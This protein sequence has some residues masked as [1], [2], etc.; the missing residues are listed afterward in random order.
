MSLHTTHECGRCL[1]CSYT[2]GMLGQH[3]SPYQI[4]LVGWRRI[5]CGV[6]GAIVSVGA[7]F[8]H[9]RKVRIH[10]M[11]CIYV[12]RHRGMENHFAMTTP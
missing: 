12:H 7:S 3:L 2:S 5:E 4:I 1:L 6:A 10:R 11:L 9:H 8:M